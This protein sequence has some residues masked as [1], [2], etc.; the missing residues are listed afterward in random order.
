MMIEADGEKDRANGGGRHDEHENEIVEFIDHRLSPHS[1]VR[2]GAH[3][4]QQ[5]GRV[6]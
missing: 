5:A 6:V 2:D 3:S 1:R 4:P